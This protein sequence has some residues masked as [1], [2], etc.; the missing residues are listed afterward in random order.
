MNDQFRAAV[1][2]VYGN[3]PAQ[4]QAANLWL[5]G[6]SKT[7]EAWGCA[8]ALLES[9]SGASVEQRF[10][11][12]NLL[13]SKTRS[14]WGGLN[15]QHRSQLADAFGAL[16]RGM[17]LAPAGTSSPAAAAFPPF[18]LEPP[19]LLE[20]VARLAATAAALG[21][22]VA[23]GRHMSLA[24]E[25]AAAAE[26]DR[27]GDE[28]LLRC[29]LLVLQ[30][31]AE[32][33]EALD[34]VR[35][36]ALMSGS[37]GG[38][39]GGGLASQRAGVVASVRGVMATATGSGAAAGAGHWGGGGSPS[40]VSF[41]LLL[42]ALRCL[43]AWVRLDESGCADGGMSPG[44]LQ[45][46][47]PGLLPS[48]LGLLALPPPGP[49]ASSP[50]AVTPAGRRQQ[51]PAIALYAAVG[52]LAADLLGPGSRIC[53]AAAGGEAADV[54][55]A[56]AALEVLIATGPQLAATA[57]AEAA[58]EAGR[59][60]GDAGAAL[61]ALMAWA[62]V[63]VAVAERNADDLATGP[64]ECAVQLANCVVAALVARPNRRELVETCTDYFLALNT[65]PTAE[66]HPALAAPLYG[67]LLPIIKR[68][69]SYPANFEDWESEV[70]EDEEAFHRPPLPGSVFFFVWG[71]IP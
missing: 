29:S 17:L 30:L 28:A 50:L 65:V 15:P 49:P 4:R 46:M 58:A 22:P 51:Q 27:T 10:F 66:R 57:A 24:Q 25:L 47:S 40:S 12:A 21:G 11:A 14:D 63:A 35:R 42:S 32:E 34:S 61:A 5:D 8:L 2:A 36:K 67:A 53:T 69:V 71:L 41:P 62:R 56:A 52:D 54:A 64:R 60:G 20:R 23:A 39:A 26:A 70:E 45:A 37:G 7:P 3:D 6:F 13:A 16:L 44:E 43:S 33:A 31:L 9:T 55:A 1:A 18:S 68:A 48:T 19:P 59:G 38:A